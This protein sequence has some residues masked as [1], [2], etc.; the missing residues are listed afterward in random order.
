MEQL[1][2]CGLS[3]SNTGGVLCDGSRGALKQPY[4]FNG[5]IAPG[6]YIDENTFFA[7]MLANAGLSKNNP[8]K[9]FPTAI[10]EDFT[11]S[12]EANREGTL[13]QGFK[14]VLVEGRPAYQAKMFADA[15]QLKAW[16]KWN[17][18]TIRLL[19]FDSNNRFWGTKIGD[20]IKG[21]QSKIF[22]TGNRLASTQNVEEGVVTVTVSILNVNEYFDQAVYMPIGDNNID[23]IQGLVD[24]D[25]YL[26]SLT[27]NVAII[28]WRLPVTQMG[29]YI[30]AVEN[31]GASL[32]DGDLFAAKYGSSFATT[33][34]IDSVTQEGNELEIT[35]DPTE[36]GTVP[37]GGLI[38]VIPVNPEVL[39][40]NPNNVR[41]VELDSIII[42]KPA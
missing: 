36:F 10:V 6:G 8:N 16:R 27:A 35:F 32:V 2:L 24:M 39:A 11:D 19:E 23:E 1:S 20:K 13:N 25:P 9:L 37:A 33:L 40:A 30:N 34:T 31:F 5:E 7:L 12:S 14:M 3:N 26:V 15:I 18:K 22:V 42:K 29:R 4:I 38:K 21:F 41:G 17:N 28:G